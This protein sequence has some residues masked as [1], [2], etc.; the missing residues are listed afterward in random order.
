MRILDAGCGLG[1]MTQGLLPHADQIDAVDIS[2]AMIDAGQRT[3]YG[4]DSRIRWL[5]G[6]VDVVALRPPY[7]LIVAAAS[8]HWMPWESTLPR[9]AEALG[10]EGYLAVVENRISPSSWS[11]QLT[12][13][14]A[15]YSM[16]R[17]FQPY[18]M[19]T[20]AEELE[21]RGLF[22]QTGICE[23][24]SILYR[25]SIDE[26][27]EAIHATNG[28]S[29]ERMD[30]DAAPEFD[31]RVREVLL[32]HCPDGVVEQ[33]ISARV[34]YGKPLAGRVDHAQ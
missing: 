5:V 23:T 17:D 16:N 7:A 19:L 33:E 15:Q 8:L 21:K 18:T 12:P 3:P 1:Q 28:F 11:D 14:F 25:Q 22:Q 27:I 2:A 34:I 31:R 24:A 32:A 13:L 10:P 20:V 6:S 30:P 29:R 9:F 4:A 26:V